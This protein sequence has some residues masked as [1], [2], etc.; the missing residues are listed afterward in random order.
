M[1][2]LLNLASELKWNKETILSKRPIKSNLFS[3]FYFLFIVCILLLV[4]Y[5][6]NNF[7]FK[8]KHLNLHNY[9]FLI[10]HLEITTIYSI[11]IRVELILFPY[12]LLLIEFEFEWFR[13]PF[14]FFSY[15]FHSFSSFLFFILKNLLES[16]SDLRKCPFMHILF[17]SLEHVWSDYHFP[18]TYLRSLYGFSDEVDW[19]RDFSTHFLTTFMFNTF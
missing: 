7:C 18:L 9:G 17:K 5:I 16:T 12:S 2:S 15:F 19:I 8:K 1:N 3:I 14:S 4:Y 10:Y 13:L 6:L 11:E